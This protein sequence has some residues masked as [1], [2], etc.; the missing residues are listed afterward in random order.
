MFDILGFDAIVCERLTIT[1]LHFLWQGAAIGL[2]AACLSRVL[3]RTSSQV[4]YLIHLTALTAMCGSLL[5]TLCVVKVSE[6]AVLVSNLPSKNLEIL[7]GDIGL[8]SSK[9][10]PVQV[11]DANPASLAPNSSFEATDRSAPSQSSTSQFT[12]IRTSSETSTTKYKVYLSGLAPYVTSLYL[13]GVALLL[14]RLLR[15]AWHTRRLGRTASEVTDADLVHR[16]K[17]QA[18]RLGLRAL[19]VVRWCQQV[20]V[21]IVIGVFRPMVLLPAYAATGLTIDQLQAV[22]A[23]ELAHIRRYDLLVNVLQRVVESLLFFHPAVWWVSRQMANER[24][25]ACDELVLAVGTGRAQYADALVKMAELSVQYGQP[26]VA[27]LA[28]SGSST[29]AFKRRI[30]KV[31]QIDTSPRIRPGRI[32]AVVSSM[33]VLL[34]LATLFF[35]GGAFVSGTGANPDS[36]DSLENKSTDDEQAA[37]RELDRLQVFSADSSRPGWIANLKQAT[38][39]SILQNVVE[40]Q[41]LL[42]DIPTTADFWH[43]SS[44]ALPIIG[45]LKSLTQVRFIG[46]DLRGQIGH[47]RELQ[48]L[49]KFESLPMKFLPGD[50]AEL[51]AL[52]NLEVIDVNLSTWFQTEDETAALLAT[53]TEEERRLCE[54]NGDF[55]RT[56]HHLSMVLTDAAIAKLQNLKQLKV[57]DLTHTFVTGKGL[58]ALAHLSNL[59]QFT[60]DDLHLLTPAGM[61]AIGSLKNLRRIPSLPS[62]ATELVE[63][64]AG[65]QKLEVLQIKGGD[66]TDD[67]LSHLKNLSSLKRLDILHSQVTDAGLKQLANL[68]KLE[69][70]DIRGAHAVTAAG[71]KQLQ[72]QLPLCKLIHTDGDY[73]ALQT[74]NNEAIAPPQSPEAPPSIKIGMTFDEVVQ[75]KGKH[76]RPSYGKALGQFYLHYDDVSIGVENHPIGKGGGT[77]FRIDPVNENAEF[78]LGSTPYAD[79][80]QVELIGLT[81]DQSLKQGWQ[82][83]GQPFPEP[84][85][86]KQ[87]PKLLAEDRGMPSPLFLFEIHG[88]REKPSIQYQHRTAA[89]SGDTELPISRAYRQAILFD[90]LKNNSKPNWSDAPTMFLSD[91]AWGPWRKIN[92]DGQFSDPVDENGFYRNA[93]SEVSSLGIRPLKTNAKTAINGTAP[94]G[95]ILKYPAEFIRR[96]AIEIEAIP[97]DQ[98]NRQSVLLQP[99]ILNEQPV[100]DEKVLEVEWPVDPN[101]LDHLRMRVRPFRHKYVFENVN[102]AASQSPKNYTQFK[103]VYTKLNHDLSKPEVAETPPL[104]DVSVIDA[105]TNLPVTGGR[106][107]VR[108]SFDRHAL[109]IVGKPVRNVFDL[110]E[111]FELTQQGTFPIRIPRGME[112]AKLQLQTSIRHPD[113]VI[114]QSFGFWPFTLEMAADPALVKKKLFNGGVIKL[115]RGFEISGLVTDPLD[116]PV[117]GVRIYAATQMPEYLNMPPH[118]VTD[119]QGRYQF[120]VPGH[121]GFRLMFVSANLNRST[122]G[123]GKSSDMPQSNFIAQSITIRK[124]Y[125]EQPVV[126]LQSGTRIVGVVRDSAGQPLP[127]VV[128]QGNG[129]DSVYMG[130]PENMSRVV[131]D[132]KGRYELPAQKFP[133]DVRVS[134][135][136]SL[137]GWSEPSTMSV[138]VF[139]PQLVTDRWGKLRQ[140]EENVFEVDFVPVKT[141]TIRAR[142][143]NAKGQPD[144]EADIEL[145]GQIPFPGA[146]PE[147]RLPHW[148]RAFT[149]VTDEPGL[150]ELKAPQGL[151]DARIDLTNEGLRQP[152]VGTWTRTV[153]DNEKSATSNTSAAWQVLDHD[154]DTIIVGQPAPGLSTLNSGAGA[155]RTF[156]IR[157]ADE[158]ISRLTTRASRTPQPFLNQTLFDEVRT[159]TIAFLNA[160]TQVDP[161]PEQ[162]QAII[163]SMIGQVTDPTSPNYRRL[164][165]YLA[166]GNAYKD[167]MW[168]VQAATV[169]KSLTKAELST[170]MAGLRDLATPPLPWP[171]LIVGSGGTVEYHIHEFQSEQIFLGATERLGSV[172]DEKQPGVVHLDQAKLLSWPKRDVPTEAALQRWVIEHGSGDVGFVPSR[173]ELVTFR[174]GKLLKLDTSDWWVI[175]QLSDDELRARIEKDGGATVSMADYPKHGFR[176]VAPAPPLIAMR[177]GPFAGQGQLFVFAVDATD[178]GMH[179]HIRARP[180]PERSLDFLKVPQAMSVWHGPSWQ[181]LR[182]SLRLATERSGADAPQQ[183]RVLINLDLFNGSEYPQVVALDPA[184]VSNS[185]DIYGPSGQLI[186]GLVA[187][188]PNDLPRDE[189]GNVIPRTVQ[190]GQSLRLLENVNL[191]LAY[192]LAEPGQYQITFGGQEQT[193]S[194]SH[195]RSCPQSN[196]LTID[197]AAGS[198]PL[199][200]KYWRLFKDK[201]IEPPSSNWSLH[202][203]SVAD[204]QTLAF[205]RP[206]YESTN[207]VFLTF[208]DSAEPVPEQKWTPFGIDVKRPWPKPRDVLLGKTELGFAH[209]LLPP[210][211]DKEWPACQEH[212][213]ERLREHLRP[214]AD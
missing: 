57:L 191:G 82:P 21:P 192:P 172:E 210:L 119:N 60:V 180:A 136:N 88:L 173:D 203:A 35:S 64:L 91:E 71:V 33:A 17:A 163:N 105:Q 65:L 79:A 50:L 95:L 29:T 42:D 138:D 7:T 67:G 156:P 151:L 49:R 198:V 93:Y 68:K 13:V 76:Y 85:W 106:V 120:R 61:K 137:G 99:S 183:G 211:A 149:P 190:P 9:P 201:P 8:E 170:V 14:T 86:V 87:L 80:P 113:Y 16:M 199:I 152:V 110:R 81:Y 1:L 185:F 126:K 213:K 19:P 160:T 102:Y 158:F 24:E 132:S 22:I 157:F 121:D 187:R 150:F 89:I 117:A 130:F 92:R 128:V 10:I 169:R 56:K 45:R 144:T 77:V 147:Q 48:N 31:L 41:K 167:L 70:L 118:A 166:F 153:R 124:E 174:K 214:V 32:A 66:L 162:Q 205:R 208:T 122:A 145:T 171:D 51:G 37:W 143:F 5:V 193:L 182:T 129:S 90:D 178:M 176:A 12:E 15:S 148:R 58:E 141:V 83:N 4:R 114:D 98:S 75:I 52:K 94:K 161:S 30:L 207:W 202:H 184:Q 43:V 74:A 104:L 179:L 38:E 159:N 20:P 177:T 63:P 194:L 140:G 44:D 72:E 69:Q 165:S 189:K 100:G 116:Q 26:P 112:G 139:M 40:Y 103:T 200:H 11:I 164:G 2:V 25:Q 115:K 84:D 108:W 107:T 212:I 146:N 131:T 96:Y 127:N 135:F 23:H 73:E 195:G 123:N 196:L 206:D 46:C 55:N 188:L 111:E 6:P 175:D 186:P 39:S 209:L 54:V 3:Q 78:F 53:L 142:A 59:E 34:M 133:V 181:G 109:N 125:G 36:G 97:T 47:L 62:G 101:S 154:D 168:R 27:A 28:S 197:V 134:R 18:E 204:P 155:A